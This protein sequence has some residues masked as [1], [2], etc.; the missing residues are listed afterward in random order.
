VKLITGAEETLQR[1]LDPRSVA[2]I[3]ASSKEGTLASWPL[4][5]LQQYGYAGRLIPVNPNR[6]EIN[7]LACAPSVAAIEGAVDVAVITLSRENTVAAVTECAEAGVGAVVLPAQGFGE[8]GEDGRALESSMLQI[9]QKH[10]MRIHGPNSDGIAN[11]ATGAVMSIQPVLGRGVEVGEVAVITQSGATAGSLISR[12]SAEG[13]G[14]RMYASA[15]NEIDLGFADYLSVAIQ[16]P[17]VKVILSF[18]EAI[19][20]P[21]DFVKVAEVA[22]EF[23]KPIIAIKVGRTGQAAARAAAHTGAL[24]GEDRIYDALFESLG[25][26]RV[27]E[28]S[29]I[30]ATAKLF[31]SAGP[32]PSA[33]IGLMSVSGGQ[34]GA[35]A[36]CAAGF[37]LDLPE[38]TLENQADLQEMLPHGN[39]LNP[40]DLTGDV[41]TRPTL[42]ADTYRIFDGDPGIDCVVYARKDLTGEMGVLAARELVS[43]RRAAKTALAIYSMDGALNATEAAVFRDGGVPVYTS[44]S[45]LFAAVRGLS[46]LGTAMARTIVQ[47]PAEPLTGEGVVGD[48]AA[49]SLLTDAGVVFPRE[50]VVTDADR[51]VEV[52]LEAG[53]PVA[54]KL[55]SARIPHKTE[56]GGV[57]LNIADEAGVRAAFELLMKR[58]RAVLDGEN[59]EG[60]LVQQQIDDGVE[61]I[62]GV[63]NDAQ[64][65]PFVLVG[66]GGVHAE[67]IKDTVLRPAPVSEPE[68]R[69]MIN[70][71]QGRLLLSGWR[72]APAADVDAL[73]R[74][75]ASVS[76]F[77]AQHRDTLSELD[78][79]PVLVRPV[80]KGAVAVDALIV[81]K[82]DED[83]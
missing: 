8:S 35:L 62:V 40:C 10:G 4:R 36:D 79:N 19:R 60:I 26:I 31:L 43:A 65:G 64:F 58:G 82:G 20:R 68:A 75:V 50:E 80:G 48:V 47:P 25:I 18:I 71:L 55:A 3:G 2:L 72:G 45:E 7:G 53:F 1:M 78:V 9:A 24:A 15:G 57:L 69:D 61:F 16:D 54:L 70:A 30:V 5:L 77:G 11:F 44:A 28:L 74:T 34:A 23:G 27:E 52:A 56:V 83:E 39:G 22:R 51:A 14:T 32:L 59:P 21:E 73:A 66:T 33:S 42:A 67:L 17:N 37:G 46:R 12:L 76:R 6:T 49:R 63:V 38:L 41:A 13:I 29:E 81:L